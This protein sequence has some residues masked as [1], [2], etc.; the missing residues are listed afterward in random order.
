MVRVEINREIRMREPV[1]RSRDEEMIGKLLDGG[2]DEPGAWRKK[3]RSRP[4]MRELSAA[5]GLVFAL[6]RVSD[7]GSLRKLDENGTSLTRSEKKELKGKRDKKLVDA[8]IIG[9]GREGFN[10]RLLKAV[11][12]AECLENCPDE[13]RAWL[14][15]FGNGRRTT[16]LLNDKQRHYMRLLYG[17]NAPHRPC[18]LGEVKAETGGS[19]K[20]G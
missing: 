8:L 4:V 20:K 18:T 5:E 16:S 15:S 3:I 19:L 13:V 1:A 6:L 12:V 11:L 10:C 9:R 14:D 2:V 7:Y 17:L